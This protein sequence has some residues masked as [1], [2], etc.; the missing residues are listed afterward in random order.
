MYDLHSTKTLILTPQCN[1]IIIF[2][3]FLVFWLV[4]NMEKIGEICTQKIV[5]KFCNDFWHPEIGNSRQKKFKVVIIKQKQQ[6]H[7]G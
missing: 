1:I 4:Y 3:L 2:L 7:F 5:I 6:K